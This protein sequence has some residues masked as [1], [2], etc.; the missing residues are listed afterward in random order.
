MS[1]RAGIR[2]RSSAVLFGMP[3]VDIAIGPDVETGQSRGRARGVVAIG[4]IATGCFAFG[5]LAQGI[6]AVGGSALG[7][8]AFG[9]GSVGL[10]AIGGL[11]VGGFALGGAAIGLVA[12]GGLAIGY[13]AQGGAA[14]GNYIVSSYRHSPEAVEFFGRWL[15]DFLWRK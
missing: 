15:P 1:F 3:L 9:G 5:G 8:V 10:V 11:A 4:D 13:Y 7:V 2:K 6:I 14:F 12:V